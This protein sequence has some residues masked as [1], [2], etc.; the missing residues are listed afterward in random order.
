ML[1][2]RHVIPDRKVVV[3]ESQLVEQIVS[4]S[5]VASVKWVTAGNFGEIDRI[6]C[7]L[8]LSNTFSPVSVAFSGHLSLRATQLK[9]TLAQV[10]RKHDQI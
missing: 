8:P 1:S 9:H 4:P 10:R 3:S 6:A 7:D 2:Q 5:I